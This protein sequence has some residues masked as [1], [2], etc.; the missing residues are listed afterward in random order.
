MKFKFVIAASITALLALP[1]YAVSGEY[2]PAILAKI[3]TP[4]IQV[5]DTNEV[6]SFRGQVFRGRNALQD[7]WRFCVTSY[8]GCA[9]V[10]RVISGPYTPFPTVIVKSALTGKYLKY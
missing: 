7:A 4:N 10:P 9:G 3:E 5:L 1:T 6:N 2:N 8:P